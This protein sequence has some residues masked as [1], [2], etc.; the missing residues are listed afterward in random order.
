[1][2]F[3]RLDRLERKLRKARLKATMRERLDRPVKIG[4]PRLSDA[5]MAS[6]SLYVEAALVDRVKTEA[7]RRDISVNALAR[8]VFSQCLPVWENEPVW[9]GLVAEEDA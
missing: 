4:R 2:R 5:A 1:M 8:S 3:N 6:M 9:V 7:K